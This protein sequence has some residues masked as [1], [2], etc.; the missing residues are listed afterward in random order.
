MGGFKPN[1]SPLVAEQMPMDRMHVKPNPKTGERELVDPA[2][3]I[4]RIYLYFY[5]FINIGALGMLYCMI[6]WESRW[7]LTLR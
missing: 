7:V 4:T 1:I 6:N 5:L 2:V 3:T